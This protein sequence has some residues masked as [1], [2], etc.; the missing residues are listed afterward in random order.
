MIVSVAN[1]SVSILLGA[2]AKNIVNA[3]MRRI[4]L[5]P[6]PVL[7]SVTP[8]AMNIRDHAPYGNSLKLAENDVKNR[9]LS[10]SKVERLFQRRL[11]VMHHLAGQVIPCFKTII[12]SIPSVSGIGWPVV[13]SGDL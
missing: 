4:G 12:I 2:I 7:K 5:I 11:F 13:L 10:S 1:P 8:I 3:P 9:C 6:I